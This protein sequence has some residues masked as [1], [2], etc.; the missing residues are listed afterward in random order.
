MQTWNEEHA[1]AVVE[2]EQIVSDYVGY[3]PVTV[4]DGH[5]LGPV[6]IGMESIFWQS[7]FQSILWS[8]PQTPPSTCMRRAPPPKPAGPELSRSRKFSGMHK[9]PWRQR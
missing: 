3:I 6:F 2:I 7:N 5:P 1:K 8:K 4:D 9:F